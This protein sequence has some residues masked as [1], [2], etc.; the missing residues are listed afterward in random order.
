VH[1][2]VIVIPFN[3]VIN[4][5]FEV[6]FPNEAIAPMVSNCGAS[7]NVDSNHKHPKQNQ[8]FANVH[9]PQWWVT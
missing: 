8:T 2:E 1:V 4:F 6:A 3:N 9:K 5:P 7:S